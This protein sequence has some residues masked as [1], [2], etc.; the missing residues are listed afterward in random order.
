[1][2]VYNDMTLNSDSA[3]IFFLKMLGFYLFFEEILNFEIPEIFSMTP[4]IY[5]CVCV[6][7]YVYVCVFVC[8]HACP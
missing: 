8:M 1:M 2:Y 4:Y 3:Y 5:L 7:V 6:C